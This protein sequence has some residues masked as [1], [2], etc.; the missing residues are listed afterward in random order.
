[1]SKRK[2]PLMSQHCS[3]P[4]Q[5]KESKSTHFSLEVGRIM[6]KSLR[7]NIAILALSGVVAAGYALGD[8]QRLSAQNYGERVTFESLTLQTTK[9]VDVHAEGKSV[10]VWGYL[11]MPKTPTERLPA[12]ILEHG[13]GGLGGNVA[14]WVTE[15]N[16]I[17]VATFDLDSFTGRG[18]KEICTGRQAL[19]IGSPLV[20]VY[21]A[22]AVLA[23]NP[24]ID[25]G[26]IA[27][28]GFSRGGSVTL[29]A[30]EIRFQQAWM[31]PGGYQFAAYLAVYPAICHITLL[32]EEQ[33]VDRPI[34]IFHGAA[35]DWTPA[36][37]CRPHVD[38]LRQAGKDVSMIEY[39]GAHHGFDSPG[40]VE[41][42]PDLLSARA[43]HFTEIAEGEFIDKAGQH[44]DFQQALQNSCFAR[45]AHNG[46]NPDA[47]RK[48]VQDVTEFLRQLFKLG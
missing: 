19:N 8:P 36:N 16:R 48:A 22:L 2:S 37:Q 9:I 40:Q 29:W 20:D 47:R 26:R 42:I 24:R 5:A 3:C 4:P 38:R 41:W 35:D 13:C 12:V 34:R 45:G 44:L 14:G 27:L 30:S 21:R 23:S 46:G 39:T 6:L 32:N 17:G 25:P 33:V 11:S 18:I 10:L 28:M 15:L 31:P 1:M 7:K 43:C